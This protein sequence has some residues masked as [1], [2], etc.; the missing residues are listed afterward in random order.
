MSTAVATRPRGANALAQYQD[1]KKY[2]LLARPEDLEI[3]G[4]VQ[5][6]LVVVD[7]DPREVKDGG[8]VHNIQGQFVPGRA[9]V[10]R[11]AD[12]AGVSFVP[13]KCTVEK[14]GPR[15]WVGKAVGRRRRVDGVTFQDVYDE[16]EF[17]VDVR[18]QELVE[19]AR[20]EIQRG[21]SA[22]EVKVMA[23]LRKD[24]LT[25]TKFGRQRAATG[26]R[27]RVI[28]AL[29]GFKASFKRDELTRPFVMSRV[30]IDTT[31]LLATPGLQH[32]A[33]SHFLGG[34]AAAA[35][36]PQTARNVTTTYAPVLA[37]PEYAHDLPPDEEDPPAVESAAPVS[38]PRVVAADAKIE[39][40][41]KSGVVTREQVEGDRVKFVSSVHDTE[42]YASYLT[43]RVKVAAE[44]RRA[45]GSTAT[46]PDG[47]ELFDPPAPA[48]ETPE[49]LVATPRKLDDGTWGRIV[50]GHV[51]EGDLITVQTKAGKEWQ[52]TV[53]K[54]VES[55]EHGTVVVSNKLED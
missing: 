8:D 46:P 28:K 42:A 1:R 7:I 17:D 26:A 51:E 48:N 18:E 33:L 35:Y 16:Y 9:A 24:V 55:T 13:E 3:R 2:N 53:V 32:E 15:C 19:N 5:V 47:G 21:G 12:A 6:D 38:D 49:T 34:S 22:T 29:T 30:T 54:V 31:K 4:P 36:G 11:I 40:A 14:I 25:L 39:A 44:K 43:E 37:P 45:Q 41:I 27:L 23:K 20:A 52:E 50:D 10:D